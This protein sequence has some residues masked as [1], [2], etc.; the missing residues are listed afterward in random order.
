MKNE[1]SNNLMCIQMR[2][3]VEKWVEK[4]RAENLLSALKNLT[5]SMF[6]EITDGKGEIVNTADIVGVFTPETMHANTMR[7]NG[8]WLC[9]YNQ[10]H[11]KF[12][13]CVCRLEADRKK[14]EKEADEFYEIH[15]YRPLT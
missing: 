8:H 14:R 1:I 6:I 13:E 3:G 15:G 5:T 2:S 10:W 9:E 4:H 7:K 11:E 12:K